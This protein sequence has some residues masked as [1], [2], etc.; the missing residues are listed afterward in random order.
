LSNLFQ[1]ALDRIALAGFCKF[2]DFVRYRFNKLAQDFI[3]KV[4]EDFVSEHECKL[5]VCFPGSDCQARRG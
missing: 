2:N 3:D 5:Y 1:R 4:Y